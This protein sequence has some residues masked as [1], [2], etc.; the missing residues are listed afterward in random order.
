[1]THRERVLAAIRHTTPDRVPVDAI[2][3]ENAE[4]I[5][6]LLGVPTESVAAQLG[7][8]GRV[9]AAGYSGERPVRQ[10]R[11]LSVWGTED[12]NDYGTTHTYPLGA[13]GTVAEVDRYRWPDP[14]GF[15]FD[16]LRV[17]LQQGVGEVALRGPYWVS[18][19]L[20]CTACNLMGMEEAMVKM[21][22]DPAVFEA[23]VE[24][25]Y[26]FS[27]G[28][29]ERFIEA[30]GSRL[31]ILYLAD[32]FASQRGL[33]MDPEHWRR[34]LKPRYAKLFAV[35]KRLGIPVW[36]HSCGDVTAVLPD[37]IE[38]GMDVWETVQLHAL[39]MTPKDLKERYGSQITFFGGVN[40]QFLPFKTP[41][42]VTEEVHRCIDMLGEGG[43][44]IC[45]P[46]HHVKPDV[47]AA[48]AV[49]LFEAARGYRRPGITL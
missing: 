40:T 3:I 25:V 37:L 35:G 32:D 21:L 45:G 44:Y 17:S 38:I 42:E 19:P 13:A 12:D 14:A 16:A 27:L 39:P 1:M 47:P 43:G 26:Q 31:D 8:D 48:N 6:H 5:G 20:L 15:D 41:A 33:I 49:A 18:G 2:C 28:Y 36:F 10:G 29:I 7:I 4:S 23:C 34:F 22:T 11:T 9:V 46:D 30:V 24:N